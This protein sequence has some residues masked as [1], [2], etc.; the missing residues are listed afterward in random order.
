VFAVDVLNEPHGVA[1]WGGH[2]PTTDYNRYCE[3]A[4]SRLSARFPDWKGLWLVEGVQ[5]NAESERGR[6]PYPQ[7]TVS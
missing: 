6:P 2:N 5:Y 7:V 4:I 1:S 3:R